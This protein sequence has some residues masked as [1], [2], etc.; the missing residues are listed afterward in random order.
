MRPLPRHTL[1][2]D[3]PANRNVSR[4]GDGCGEEGLPSI[5]LYEILPVLDRSIGEAIQI[6]DFCPVLESCGSSMVL[7]T[8]G[9]APPPT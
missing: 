8:G 6:P 3:S 7:S 2:E 9:G 5:R 1:D 4:A